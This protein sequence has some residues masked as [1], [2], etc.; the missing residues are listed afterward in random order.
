MQQRQ[1]RGVW[2]IAAGVALLLLASNLT[3]GLISSDLAEFVAK[4][5]L[6]LWLMTGAVGVLAGWRGATATRHRPARRCASHRPRLT[7]IASPP[8]AI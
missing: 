5:R 7:N 1:R 3:A 2:P 6:W 8:V 4:Y